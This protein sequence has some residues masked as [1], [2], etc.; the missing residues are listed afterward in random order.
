VHASMLSNGKVAMW[1][2]FGAAMGSEKIWDPVTG[3]FQPTPSG[4]NLF[5]AGHVLLP[6]GRLFT[7]GG[8]VLAY[9]GITDTELLNPLTGSWTAGPQMARGRW[10][11]TAT[12]LPDGRV[13]IVSGDGIPDTAGPYNAFYKPS[14][15]VPEVY[16]PKT[17]TL[18]S[19][20]SAARQMPLYPF[21]FVAPD[22]RV[23]DAG[24]DTT[25]RLLNVQ[26]G[27]WT[28]LASKSP[29]DG[30]S[31]VMYRP[32]KILKSGTWADP[33]F[34]SDVPVT[35]R[36]AALDLNETVPTWREVA[37]MKWKRTFHTLTVLP[38]G[39]VLALG[40]TRSPQGNDVTSS[41][42][43]EPEIWHPETDTWT[44]MASSARPR[45]YHNTSLLLPDGRILLAG[46]GRLDGSMMPNEQTAEIFSPPYLN[47][48]ARPTVTT[49]PDRLRYGT[50]F[51]LSTPDADRIAKVTLV[52]TGSVTHGL[53]MDQ[54]YQELN[55]TKSG[56]T[57]TIDGPANPNLAPPGVY[58]VFIVD[59]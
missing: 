58:Y 10:Y 34:P 40:G 14:N 12:T 52:R 51:T 29:I 49:A 56:T 13:L 59:D 43:L 41:A 15:T 4:L 27:Q 50:P 53:N 31:A 28:A 46:S 54:R 24:P 8:H 33:D 23:V 1:D 16:D 7:A 18:A 39:D 32:G 17:N 35:N 20:P 30:H 26:T 47:K 38:D 11:P 6:D 44:S 19:M 3:A 2:A 42:V 36:A 9:V 45:G 57:L 5:C 22:G 21:M 37:P 25:T 55:F 48:G